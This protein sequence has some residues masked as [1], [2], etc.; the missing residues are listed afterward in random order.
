MTENKNGI[1]KRFFHKERRKRKKCRFLSFW[2][3]SCQYSAIGGM[4]MWNWR[5]FYQMADMVRKYTRVLGG[6]ESIVRVTSREAAGGPFL[7][8]TISGTYNKQEDRISFCG[9]PAEKITAARLVC[10][11]LKELP[12]GEEVLVNAV[13][14]RYGGNRKGTKQRYERHRICMVY[15]RM[16]GEKRLENL[17]LEGDFRKMVVIGTK[18]TEIR[19]ASI[20]ELVG[21]FAKAADERGMLLLG[22]QN[23]RIFCQGMIC[24]EGELEE[25]REMERENYQGIYGDVGEGKVVEM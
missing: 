8:H 7:L 13:F 14:L 15:R 18:E 20:A 17:F 9:Y 24:R 19:K 1:R 16:A 21:V 22:E 5:E 10:L 3:K 25:V 4:D 23:A 12:G 6:G 2:K 11:Y